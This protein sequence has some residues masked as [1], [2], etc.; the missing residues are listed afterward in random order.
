MRESQLGEPDLFKSTDA[1]QF[2]MEVKER[3]ES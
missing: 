1:D 2:M 3:Y